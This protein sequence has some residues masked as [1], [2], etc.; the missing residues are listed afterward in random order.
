MAPITDTERI[1]WQYRALAV[2]A[3][4]LDRA[5]TEHLPPLQW[6]AGTT[7]ELRGICD[8]GDRAEVFTRWRD[9][10]GNP[11][12]EWSAFGGRRLR[13]VWESM[14]G[15]QFILAADLRDGEPADE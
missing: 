12:R 11:D 8:E 5:T 3:T 10:I 13:A 2:L 1:S 6:T 14:G 4:L 15:V 9:A 7:G